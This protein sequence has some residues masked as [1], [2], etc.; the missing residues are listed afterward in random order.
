M[1][2]CLYTVHLIAVSCR[3]SEVARAV[4]SLLLILDKT[5]FSVKCMSHQLLFIPSLQITS[6]ASARFILCVFFSPSEFTNGSRPCF[7]LLITGSHGR[8]TRLPAFREMILATALGVDRLTENEH[9]TLTRRW[10][11]CCRCCR[12]E[13]RARSGLLLCQMFLMLRGGRSAV[14]R[15]RWPSRDQE[16][17][18]ACRA[19]RRHFNSP[20]LARL[21]SRQHEVHFLCR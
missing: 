21:A 14:R 15:R 17:A 3:G 4:T 12:A 18:A 9:L 5:T 7:S 8:G 10:R 2:I 20:S 16:V 1:Y 13:K 11:E 6:V 19:A